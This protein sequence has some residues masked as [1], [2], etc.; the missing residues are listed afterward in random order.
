MVLDA[1]TRLPKDIGEILLS[2]ISKA[3]LSVTST[4]L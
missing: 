4:G 2:L 1:L 3:K